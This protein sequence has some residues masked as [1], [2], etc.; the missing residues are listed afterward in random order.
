MDNYIDIVFDAPPGPEAGRFI[1]VEDPSGKSIDVGEWI[2]RPDG[3]W[4]LRLR[5]GCWSQ[6]GTFFDEL[7]VA[8][9]RIAKLEVNDER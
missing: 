2:H 1:E 5:R 7:C 3:Y 4:A 9:E 6:E 8:L